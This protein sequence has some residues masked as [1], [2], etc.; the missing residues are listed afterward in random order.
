MKANSL[1]INNLSGKAFYI[2][3]EDTYWGDYA[4]RFFAALVPEEEKAFNLK[5][6]DQLSSLEDISD[7]TQTSPFFQ[8]SSVVI[9]K[10]TKYKEKEYEKGII[11]NIIKSLDGTYLVFD[12][13]SFLTARSKKLMEKIDTSYLDTYDIKKLII[14]DYNIDG[15]A[16]D[17]L[18]EYAGRD[19][20]RITTEVKKLTAYKQGKKISK[21]DVTELVANTAESAIYHFS[22]ALALQRKSQA[23]DI[24]DGFIKKGTPYSHL[25]AVL[26][27]QYRRMLHSALSPKSN[28][29]VAQY[30]GTKPF[31]IQKAREIARKYTKVQLKSCL[32]ALT[33]AELMFKSGAVPEDTAFKMALS[34]LIMI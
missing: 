24:L 23:L 2:E 21:E 1:N 11:E 34:K 30:L 5:V 16:A 19:M 27:S 20:A 18:I 12:N 32:D 25:L 33:Q 13:V 15:S 8:S 6:I 26:I 17:R 14:K 7:A 4:V 28:A 31:A 10:D 29:E 22:E 3:G 9:V